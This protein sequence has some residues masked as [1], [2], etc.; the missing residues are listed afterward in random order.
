MAL[1]ATSSLFLNTSRDDD[2]GSVKYSLLQSFPLV[3]GTFHSWRLVLWCPSFGQ[4]RADFCNKCGGHGQD[5]NV[6]PYPFTSLP[7][8]RK[9]N[10]LSLP[11]RCSF[12]LKKFVGQNVLVFVYCWAFNLSA[13]HCKWL[14]TFLC[15]KFW[16][17][18]RSWTDSLK[19]LE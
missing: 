13:V 10:S 19:V 11:R 12:K 3:L 15:F 4:D 1:S 7:G 6:I 16:L 5:S 2:S 14:Q 9:R 18:G 17:R 8:E